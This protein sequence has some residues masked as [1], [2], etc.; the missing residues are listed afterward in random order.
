[1]EDGELEKIWE[2]WDK[3]LPD[4]EEPKK[5]QN[6]IS[7]KIEEHKMSKMAKTMRKEKALWDYIE[8]NSTT[9]GVLETLKRLSED[10]N[11]EE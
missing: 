3:I 1:M 10:D 8:R 9:K 7:R 2:R 6:F 5:K 11:E 4:E